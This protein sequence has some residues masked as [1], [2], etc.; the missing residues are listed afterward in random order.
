M[1]GCVAETSGILGWD[2]A[3]T[4]SVDRVINRGNAVG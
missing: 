1:R 2:A 4:V 3:T